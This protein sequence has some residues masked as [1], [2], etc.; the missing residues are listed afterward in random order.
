[1]ISLLLLPLIAC[2][3]LVFIHV[4]F[5]AFVLKRGI[6]FID[7]ALAQWAALGYLVGH[8]FDIQNPYQLFLVGFGFT[9]I[10]AFILSIVK[11]LF[12]ESNLQEAVIGVMYIF[13]ASG[14]TA[15]I[16][17]TGMEGHNFKSMLSGHLLFIQTQDLILAIS[18]YSVIGIILFMFNSKLLNGRSTL[19]DFAFYTLFGCVVT[20]SVK[21]VGILLVFSFLVLPILSIILFVKSIKKQIMIGWGVG[22]FGSI[23]G[24]GCSLILD[25]PPSLSIVLVLCCNFAV[26]VLAYAF[27][28]AV[29]R[30]NT[31]KLSLE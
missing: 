31:Q 8:F 11:P 15:L 4:Y 23:I 10:A 16:S 21:M 2:A 6:L 12:K 30:V 20:S 18:L 19:S 9:V 28:H 5:G 29:K 14:A 17:S 26:G 1:M 25:I 22:I 3:V 24:L 27:V 7:L 13:A